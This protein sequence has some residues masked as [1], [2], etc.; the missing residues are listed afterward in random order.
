MTPRN[1][2]AI[3]RDGVSPQSLH[4]ICRGRH[5][6]MEL[7]C[8]LQGRGVA[9]EPA[10]DMQ[11]QHVVAEPSCDMQGS[12][13][14]VYKGGTAVS[15]KNVKRYSYHWN[16]GQPQTCVIQNDVTAVSRKHYCFSVFQTH[17]LRFKMYACGTYD[18][19]L[20]QAS[21]TEK[22]DNKA[23]PKQACSKHVMLL[24]PNPPV[25]TRDTILDDVLHHLFREVCRA[26]GRRASASPFLCPSPCRTPH[27]TVGTSR[28]TDRGE[29]DLR[30]PRSS[31]PR[32]TSN[33][34]GSTDRAKL[35][36]RV[37]VDPKSTS[38]SDPLRARGLELAAACRC[39]LCP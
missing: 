20:P 12:G 19:A 32:P 5:A 6:V 23:T 3:C 22:H 10:G 14:S 21:K 7:S 35:S 31:S 24:K 2:R 17:V 26:S 37:S 11:G 1:N 28:L 33:N 8:D 9:T 29:R 18:E 39:C 13:C 36:P 15:R 25:A 4:A 34:R 27:N 38:L 16:G 30:F